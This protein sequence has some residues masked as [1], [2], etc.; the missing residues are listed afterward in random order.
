MIIDAAKYGR[1][2]ELQHK[3]SLEGWVSPSIQ[4]TAG[5][6][7]KVTQLVS[8]Q[9]FLSLYSKIFSSSLAVS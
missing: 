1:D 2:M 6:S 4:Q 5:A 8:D 7:F 3:K 9:A